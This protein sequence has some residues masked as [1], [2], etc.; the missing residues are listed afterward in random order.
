MEQPYNTPTWWIS[1]PTRWA[2]LEQWICNHRASALLMLVQPSVRR[3]WRWEEKAFQVDTEQQPTNQWKK[4]SEWNAH[5]YNTHTLGSFIMDCPDM[6]AVLESSCC[7]CWLVVFISVSRNNHQRWT[8]LTPNPNKVGAKY[9]D[10]ISGRTSLTS[11]SLCKRRRR[12]SRS[13]AA[14][15]LFHS[16]C[17]CIWK[18]YYNTYAQWK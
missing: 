7:R 9:A 11:I 15:A 13:H 12:R 10:R 18:S 8:S 14:A 2:A 16:E 1:I 3:T 5:E 17:I 6:P 4:W